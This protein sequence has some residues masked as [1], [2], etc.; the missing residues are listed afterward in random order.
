MF[1]RKHNIIFFIAF[2]CVILILSVVPDNTPETIQIFGYKIR[3]DIVEHILIYFCLG[4]FL[5]KIRHIG[6]LPIIILGLIVAA[7]PEIIQHFLP[8]RSFDPID[9]MLNLL[10]LVLGLFTFFIFNRKNNKIA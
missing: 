8:Y 3:I 7:I 2:S 9:L 4:Y 10:G 6:I 5:Q 1:K